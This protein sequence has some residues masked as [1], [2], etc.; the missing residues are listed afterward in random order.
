MLNRKFFKKMKNL[1]IQKLWLDSNQISDIS[2]L[3]DLINI[4]NLWLGGNHINDISPLKDLKN[5]QK[6]W[7]DS[8]QIS[9]ISHLKKNITIF[10]FK[11]F[12]K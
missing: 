1:N 5:I 2:P 11:H 8:N 4:Q 6:L 12:S 10:I 7:L 3:K 9:D